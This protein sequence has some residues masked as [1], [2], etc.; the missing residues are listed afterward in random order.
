MTRSVA[1]AE[2][3]QQ[4]GIATIVAPS[5]AHIPADRLATFEAL[6]DSI[7][8]DR[9]S[10]TDWKAPQCQWVQAVARK[11]PQLT[12]AGY[13]SS[14]SVYADA[15]GDWVDESSPH[16]S[17][18][19]RGAARLTAERAWMN[20]PL[21]A[22]LFRISGIYG[23]GRNLI[24]RL[25]QGGYQT[26]GW[27]PPHFANRIHADDLVAALLAAMQAPTAG[28]IL[29]ISDDMPSPHA[30]Y[31]RELA[32][33]AGAAMP[34]ILSPQQAEA[35]LSPSVLAFFRDNKR[36][37]NQ[38]LHQSL[39]PKLQYPSFRQAIADLVDQCPPC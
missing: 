22:E 24:A 31:V 6:L 9:S 13:L 15:K 36:V 18:Q 38:Q 20:S 19:G 30:D 39:M 29:N 17:S 28:R 23:P 2:Q 33:I 34:K 25:R 32:T 10:A 5:P 4:L 12:W 1:Q 37:S 11:C 27:N 8:L 14:T 3:L 7:P 26:V 21:P 35:T 16:L